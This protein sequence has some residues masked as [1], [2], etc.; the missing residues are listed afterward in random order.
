MIN[1]RNHL[2]SGNIAEGNSNTLKHH[3]SGYLLH[4]LLANLIQG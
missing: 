2:K 3:R 1:L 4:Y